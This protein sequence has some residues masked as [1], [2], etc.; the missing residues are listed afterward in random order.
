MKMEELYLCKA[1][2]YYGIQLFSYVRIHQEE[3]IIQSTTDKDFGIFYFKKT[4]NSR[5]L[6]I[7]CKLEYKIN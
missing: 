5:I 4:S 7:G 3:T 2:L 6:P 1:Y